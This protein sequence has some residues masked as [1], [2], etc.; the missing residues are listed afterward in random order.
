[1]KFFF[2]G[3]LIKI[4]LFTKFDFLSPKKNKILVFDKDLSSE[5]STTINAYLSNK[6]GLSIDCDGDY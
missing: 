1:M 3:K 2:I 6:W 5:E 4:I